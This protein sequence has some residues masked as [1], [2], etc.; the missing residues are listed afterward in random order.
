[1]APKDSADHVPDNLLVVF[2]LALIVS[3]GRSLAVT[4][5]QCHQHDGLV[6]GNGHVHL[7][8]LFPNTFRRPPLVSFLQNRRRFFNGFF[9]EEIF[10]GVRLGRIQCVDD[11]TSR[12]QGLR[13]SLMVG[14]RKN[15][16]EKV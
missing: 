12:Q 6:D 13:S 14:F 3:G 1:L 16:A 2:D 9:D 15:P 7:T 5:Q 8:A 11:F 10:S 4:P